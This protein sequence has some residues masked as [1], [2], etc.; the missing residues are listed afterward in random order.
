MKVPLGFQHFYPRNVLLQLLRT[1]YGLKQAALQFWHEMQLAFCLMNYVVNKADP[2][3]YHCWEW[4]R[5]TLWVTWVD[6]CLIASVLSIVAKAKEKMKLCF[7]CNNIGRMEEYVG[8][9]VQYDAPKR[10]MMLTQ[11]VL[12]Q[13]FQDEFGVLLEGHVLATSVVPE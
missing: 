1:I 10:S 9:K 2:C 7:D 6:N 11:P 8:C 5:L 12:L 13:S 4:G 3:L